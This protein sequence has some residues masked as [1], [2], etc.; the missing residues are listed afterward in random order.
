METTIKSVL[1]HSN[2]F[3]LRMLIFCMLL[4]GAV[5]TV[6]ATPDEW[7]PQIKGENLTSWNF[8]AEI[9]EDEYALSEQPSQMVALSCLPEVNISLGQGGYAAITALTLVNAP[10]YPPHMYEVDIM[11]P[12]SDTVYCAQL[13]QELMVVV[14]ELP[15][16][17]SCM[18]SI[19]IED[20]LKPVLVCTSDTLPCNTDIPTIDFESYIESVT[21]NCDSDPSLWY[22]YVVQNLP[23]NAHHFTQQILVTWTATDDSGNSATCQDIIY[24]RK[25]AL[26]QI[27]FPPNI[28]ISCVNADT[29]PSNTGVPTYNGD[30]LG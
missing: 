29:D 11:G 12:L 7:L 14:H 5:F 28:S 24:L 25:P 19:F 18:S 17:N 30:P 21:D 26:G 1:T 8:F 20:K 9:S 15:T 6:S 2:Q 27:V 22:S 4:S 10:Q 23:C 3:L 16:G 13:G